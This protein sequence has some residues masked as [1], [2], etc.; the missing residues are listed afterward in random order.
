MAVIGDTQNQA[1][2]QGIRYFETLRVK[3]SIL[4]SMLPPEV[5]SEQLATATGYI[6]EPPQFNAPFSLGVIATNHLYPLQMRFQLTGTE[7][8][9]KVA[10]VREPLEYEGL[11]SQFSINGTEHIPQFVAQPTIS[12]FIPGFRSYYPSLY[13]ISALA[14]VLTYQQFQRESLT[15][16][17]SVL[18]M[19]AIITSTDSV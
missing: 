5:S 4:T 1:P 16:R 8:E 19:L 14:G 9:I 17:D 3:A 15:Q 13:V 6:L 12:I 11:L 10:E 7:L 2:E 18:K